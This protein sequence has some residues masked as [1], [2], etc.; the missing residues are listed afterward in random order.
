MYEFLGN[1]FI[2]HPYMAL[3]P[4]VVFG[5]LY[6]KLRNKFILAVAVIWALYALYEELNLLRITCSGECN[7]RVDLLLFYP[8][9][10]L[11]TVVG[12]IYGITKLL[13]H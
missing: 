7:I 4:A 12:I 5:S 3:I 10:I 13:K 9:L 1:I 8:A 2:P 11:L 6:F